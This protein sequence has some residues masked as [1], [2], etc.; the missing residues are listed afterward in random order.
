MK[1]IK[2]NIYIVCTVLL[3][4]VFNSCEKLPLYKDIERPLHTLDPQQGI[5]AWEYINKPRTDT[6]FNMMLR[7]I[8]YAGL[9]AEYQKP[10]RTYIILA[11]QAI[12]SLNVTTK[13]ES[14]TS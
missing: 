9:E 14:T 6:L 5:T 10:D 8:K 3:S 11:N 1:N 12:T 4:L 2:V 7:A 13:V